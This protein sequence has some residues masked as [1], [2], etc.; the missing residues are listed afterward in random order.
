MK[1][2]ETNRNQGHLLSPMISSFIDPKNK[3]KMLADKINWS[4]F[5]EKFG[6]LYKEGVGY[7]P[8]PIRLMVGLLML[9]YMFKLSDEK[10]VEQWK[11]NPYWQYFCG[12]N[13]L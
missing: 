5:E 12:Y 9:E 4:F 10:V 13:H 8:K 7:P 1:P 6:N 11:E 2:I 3:L